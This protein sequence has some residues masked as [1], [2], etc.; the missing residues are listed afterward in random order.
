MQRP[1]RPSDQ[2][3]PRP[4]A[5]SRPVQRAASG[6][7]PQPRPLGFDNSRRPPSS[8][9]ASNGGYRPTVQNAPALPNNAPTGTPPFTNRSG[10]QSFSNPVARP[11]VNNNPGSQFSSTNASPYYP[12]TQQQLP[13]PINPVN[14]SRKIDPTQ[15][16][17]P[18]IVES[19]DSRDEFI[20]TL[21]PKQQHSINPVNTDRSNTIPLTT[22]ICHM[23]DQGNCI[24]RFMRSTT[25]IPI[26]DEFRNVC[27]LPF[28]VVVHP[29]VDSEYDEDVPYVDTTKFGGPIRC[30]NCRAYICPRMTFVNGGKAF[31]C[32]FCLS[33]TE[34]P[35]PYF[36]NLDMNHV[37]MDIAERPELWK[38]TVDLSVSDEYIGDS[39]P[40]PLAIL[41]AIDTSVHSCKNGLL[42]AVCATLIR[43]LYGSKAINVSEINDAEEVYVEGMMNGG[44]D[45]ELIDG[46]EGD[47]IVGNMNFQ[48]P[49][50]AKIGFLTFDSNVTFYAPASGK[51]SAFVVSDT[52]DVFNPTSDIWLD[53]GKDQK[54]ILDFLN[55]LPKLFSFDNGSSSFS[56]VA[57]AIQAASSALYE[58][59]KA[60]G[61]IVLFHTIIPNSG[62][63][64]L[65]TRD[66][67]GKL[68][69]DKKNP[70]LL[71]PDDGFWQ[72][73]A[74]EVVKRNVVFDLFSFPSA[75]IDLATLG[76][77]SS[78]TGGE[79]NFFPGFNPS[80]IFWLFSVLHRN[81]TRP[82]GYQ[83]FIR[84]RASKGIS[85]RNYM[86][87][88]HTDDDVEARVCGIDSDKSIAVL[89][90]HSSKLDDKLPV[91]IQCALLYTSANGTRKV[92]VQTL[93]V[94]VE[95][96]A[97][98]L[99]KHS[100]CDTSI[101]VMAKFSVYNVFNSSL[102]EVREQV[103]DKAA[104]C[105]ASYRKNCAPSSP[106][107]QLILPESLK[108]LPLYA[109]N[110]LKSKSFSTSNVPI[111]FRV[112][113]MRF[114]LSAST[115][116]LIPYLYPHVYR[117]HDMESK[118]GN[119]DQK[120]H[121]ILPQRIRSSM[122]NFDQNGAYL[123]ENGQRI[124]LW[125]GRNINTGIL[126]QLIGLSSI[127]QI[128]PM[129]H[130]VKKT[131]SLSNKQLRTL[132]GSIYR[133]YR[134]Y[135]PIYIVRSQVDPLENEVKN[136]MYEDKSFDG[137]SYVDFLISL[138]RIVQQEV[139]FVN[140]VKRK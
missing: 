126:S 29:L 129:H 33:Q 55:S 75:Y 123:I 114:M 39:A 109:L 49:P 66:H 52:L 103:T 4:Q 78:K 59:E 116:I 102:K 46:Q 67:Q 68:D 111:D 42:G 112:E 11:Q 56:C 34:T 17:S 94:N 1:N 92:R 7:Q 131:N 86:G 133:K 97:S 84:V 140:L 45:P 134:K 64:C 62:P 139:H 47:G 100:D 137:P 44:I 119:F 132:I 135:M 27:N 15:V 85:V 72:N 38:G 21:D 98:S 108:L 8:N 76:H 20:S 104:Q 120:G 124:F 24:P 6:A 41:F 3:K 19:L 130:F 125:V 80:D 16:P 89:L 74:K 118:V 115:E 10:I 13:S 87:S 57:A 63:G 101:S 96:S 51:L 81:L 18:L 23:S 99:F 14:Q 128:D 113:N 138:H 53:P 9:F 28:G 61:K 48:L 88:I 37:R 82:F 12:G 93:A 22:T 25:N 70:L 95:S 26:S 121:L 32:G 122:E 110:I 127:D 117:I 136:L 50:G 5:H 107:G 30:S 105:L 31:V 79:T 60:G 40:L 58:R 69:S 90:S 43:V 71:P 35:T 83:G 65:K 2:F 54:Q 77:V 36:C 73:L 91:Y 106:P